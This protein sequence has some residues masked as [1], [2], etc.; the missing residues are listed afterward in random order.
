MTPATTLA[1]ESYTIGSA[2]PDELVSTLLRLLD[3]AKFE[4]ETD[5]EAA[6]ASITKASSLLQVGTGQHLSEIE[7]R[8]NS[9][10]LA[11]WQANRVRGYIEDRLDKTI[12]LNDLSDITQLSKGHFC[13]AFRQTFGDPPH[14]YLIRRRLERASEL[15]LSSDTALSAIALS[16]GFSDQA[17]FCKLFRQRTGQSP[18]AWRRE[19]R[20]SIRRQPVRHKCL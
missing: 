14:A 11:A 20:A 3:A 5:P 15:M 13:R 10:G 16:A 4:F 9:G 7:N 8:G 12:R 6:R 18:A 1:A 17:H 19:R 2:R